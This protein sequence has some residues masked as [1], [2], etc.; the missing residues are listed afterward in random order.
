MN[1]QGGYLMTVGHFLSILRARWKTMAGALLTFLALGI[2]L[3]IFMPRQYTGTATVLVDIKSPDPVNGLFSQGVTTP[4]YMNTQVDLIGDE[5]VARRAVRELRLAESEEAMQNWRESETPDFE[6]WAAEYLTKYLSVSPAKDSNLIRVGFK[7]E[8]PVF[9]AAVANAF[10][11][12]YMDVTL[13]LRVNPAKT[14]RDFFDASA[15]KQRVAV[16]SAQR[17]LS[18]FQRERGLLTSDAML[19]DETRRLNEMVA[20]LVEVEAQESDSKSRQTQSQR[21]AGQTPE[22]LLSPLVSGLRAD[23]Q[24]KRARL[25]ELRDQ[26]GD[27]HPTIRQLRANIAELQGRINEETARISGGLALGSR[28]ARQRVS[29][30]RTA[31][32]A[33]REKVMRVKGA[34][35]EAVVLIRDVENAQKAYDIVLGRLSQ[36]TLESQTLQTNVTPVGS[37]SVPTKPSSPKVLRILLGCLVVGGAT[38]L[39]LVFLQEMQRPKVRRDEQLVSLLAQPIAVT[40]PAYRSLPTRQRLVSGVLQG[41]PTVPSLK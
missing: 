30:L 12:A 23:L 22:A 3:A 31:I 27:R 21:E 8:D 35:D 41:T 40:L 25:G 14:N 10:V 15:E 7:S 1:G 17:R 18:A 29:E 28:V 16:E 13:E 20:Q 9:A 39:A 11:K 2:A 34:R 4:A 36:V 19:D 5:V 37:A 6:A 26:L 33:Q 24:A 38:G 32:T